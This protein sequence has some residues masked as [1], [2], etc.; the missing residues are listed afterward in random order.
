VLRDEGRRG[1]QKWDDGRCGAVRGVHGEFLKLELGADLGEG[2]QWS[3]AL[4]VGAEVSEA[5]VQA[6]VYVD[7]EQT[8]G[9]W[10]AKFDEGVGECLHP[11]AVI[12]DV[13]GCWN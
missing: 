8:V 3:L 9:D 2:G 12:R 6:A 10:F 4:E 11:A 1:G 7:D 13:E 5:L